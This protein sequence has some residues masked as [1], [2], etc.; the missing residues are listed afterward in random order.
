MFSI[1]RRSTISMAMF[2]SGLFRACPAKTKSPVF[3]AGAGLRFRADR[4]RNDDAAKC[5]FTAASE[6]ASAE[7][8][9]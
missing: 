6:P 7:T 8:G 1:V 3:Q 5:Q 4:R 2:E 9:H